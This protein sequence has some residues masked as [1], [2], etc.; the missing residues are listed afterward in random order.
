M[1]AC[2]GM[3][4][5]LLSFI[6]CSHRCDVYRGVYKSLESHFSYTRKLVEKNL[7]YCIKSI[8]ENPL[9]SCDNILD[10]NSSLVKL[11]K[12]H[13]LLSEVS[14]LISETVKKRK[15]LFHRTSLCILIKNFILLS[16]QV[17]YGLDF[18]GWI[19]QRIVWLNICVGK[20]LNGF[21]CMAVLKEICCCTANKPSP[22]ICRIS[23]KSLFGE[24]YYR[25]TP[26]HDML[27]NV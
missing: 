17:H 4:D 5:L 21:N 18:C 6:Q 24:G 8:E 15:A 22:E 19:G 12:L 3:G 10:V 11:W 1:Y 2:C 7:V 23:S 14:C 13:A 9:H 25:E 16:W 26:F 27:C 20:Y